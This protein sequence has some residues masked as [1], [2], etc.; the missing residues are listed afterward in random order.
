[1][2]R[3]M[4]IALSLRF[5]KLV[6]LALSFVMMFSSVASAGEITVSTPQDISASA[7]VENVFQAPVNQQNSL[8]SSDKFG[9]CQTANKEDGLLQS[10]KG[11]ARICLPRK[12]LK[13]G[14]CMAN[15]N[16]GYKLRYGTGFLCSEC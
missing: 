6:A 15:G 5:A 14:E 2:K 9:E 7:N 11:G 13:C 1:M 8:L 10:V 3:K 4:C 16:Y 12:R